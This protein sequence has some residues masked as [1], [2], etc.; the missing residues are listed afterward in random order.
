MLLCLLQIDRCIFAKSNEK[1]VWVDES[2]NWFVQRWISVTNWA[3]RKVGKTT[4]GMT[5]I[6]SIHFDDF[7]EARH[8]QVY[9]DGRTLMK[10]GGALRGQ[11]E[12]KDGNVPFPPH[13]THSF[14]N[15]TTTSSSFLSMSSP[16]LRAALQS[17]LCIVNNGCRS[18]AIMPIWLDFLFCSCS[19]TGRD[20]TS[21]DVMLALHSSHVSPRQRSEPEKMSYSAG[22]G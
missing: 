10:M 6:A 19:D 18:N 8:T 4:T 14:D 22:C 9:S 16:R 15:I 1:K 3:G 2:I 17:V 20:T 13:C 7:A 21:F 5:L 11:E 12:K